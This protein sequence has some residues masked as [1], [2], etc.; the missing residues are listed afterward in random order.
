MLLALSKLLKIRKGDP[1]KNT[2]S[3]RQK[4]ISENSLYSFHEEMFK[5]QNILCTFLMNN[6]DVEK[7]FSK[8]FDC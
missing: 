1:E 2:P 4:Y 6:L 3:K 7:S 8:E 5:I